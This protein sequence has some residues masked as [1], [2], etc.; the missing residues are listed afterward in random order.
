MSPPKKDNLSVLSRQFV[1]D[2]DGRLKKSIFQVILY[3]I[4]SFKGPAFLSVFGTL[5]VLCP[6]SSSFPGFSCFFDQ[7]RLQGS[8]RGTM[9][10][11]FPTPQTL[12]LKYSA[13]NDFHFINHP[14]VTS[15][16]C[17]LLDKKGISIRHLVLKTPSSE[18]RAS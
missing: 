18:K 15:C 1:I 12:P 11:M 10:Y 6:V 7:K 8:L 13:R 5:L 2:F 14:S 3:N 17:T 9:W 16:E 4:V